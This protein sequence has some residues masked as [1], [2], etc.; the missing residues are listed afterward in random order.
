M[1]GIGTILPHFFISAFRP[2]TRSLWSAPENPD[3]ISSKVRWNTS[4]A[5]EMLSLS[6]NR[7]PISKMG[8]RITVFPLWSM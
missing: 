8:R 7:P 4:L 3:L 5:S 2:V 1:V 6:A